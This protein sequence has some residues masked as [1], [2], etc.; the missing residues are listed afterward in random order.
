[1]ATKKPSTKKVIIDG[2]MKGKTIDQEALAEVMAEF[3]RP[4]TEPIQ[5]IYGTPR[6]V[7]ALL[8]LVPNEKFF[9]YHNHIPIETDVV[10]IQGLGDAKAVEAALKVESDKIRTSLV[11]AGIT[12]REVAEADL[13][14]QRPQKTIPTTPS[15]RGRDR[16][17]AN[18]KAAMKVVHRGSSTTPKKKKRK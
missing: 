4:R 14:V 8:H 18:K 11:E 7:H 16:L 9:V 13:I 3:N 10:T 15:T 12:V 6:Y 5:V 2:P 17:S 1:M